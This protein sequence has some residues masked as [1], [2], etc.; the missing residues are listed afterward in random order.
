MSLNTN[1]KNSKE[2]VQCINEQP[3][4]VFG[5]KEQNNNKKKKKQKKIKKKRNKKQKI[6]QN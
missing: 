4:E 5:E 1:N 6:K 2:T 3:N